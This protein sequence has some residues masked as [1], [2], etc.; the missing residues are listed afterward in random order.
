MGLNP[1]LRSPSKVAKGDAGVWQRRFW[2]H[3]IRDADDHAA[4]LRYCWANP[5]RHG[6]VER[7]A[8]WPHSSI[9]RD[10]RLGRVE[11]EW[12]GEPPP[13]SFGE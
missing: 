11:P 6:L 4:H 12:S 8:D 9:H 5:V 1:T 2:E 7:P 13:G 10:I 3:H